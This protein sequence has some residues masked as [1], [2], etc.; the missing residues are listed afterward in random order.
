MM[1]LPNPVAGRER[2]E[3]GFLQ[4]ATGTEIEVFHAGLLSEL[5][6]PGQPLQ[7]MCF[8]VAAFGLYQQGEALFKRELMKLWLFLLLL[9]G[10]RHPGQFQAA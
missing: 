9:E 10:L 8:P 1:G 5:C 6:L 2:G 7:A 4:P 3:Q